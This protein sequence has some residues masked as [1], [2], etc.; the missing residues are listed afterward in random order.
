MKYKSLCKS[1]L[2]V[3]AMCTAFGTI[4][5]F[6]NTYIEAQETDLSTEQKNGTVALTKEENG[7]YTFGNGYLK[8][9]FSIT[10][11]K[12][13][14]EYLTNYRTS[15]ETKMTP[16]SSEEFVI[17]T[18][19]NSQEADGFKAPTQKIEN[20]NWGVTSDSEQVAEEKGN[21]SHM[22]DGN[23]DTY[24]HSKYKDASQE[25][26]QYPHNIYVDL[27]NEN[28][29][30]SVYYKQRVHNGSPTV[31]GH[32]KDFKLYTASSIEELKT[33]KAKLVYEGTFE[34]KEDNYVNLGKEVT[35]QYVRIEF[36]TVHTPKDSKVDKD[37]ACCSEFGFFADEAVFPEKSVSQIKASNLTV[38]GVPEVGEAN[39]YKTFR[40][41]D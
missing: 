9:T 31:S 30:K 16:A 15:G 25:E 24:Y 28:T 14:T 38:D 1:A 3:A 23:V 5:P 11:G 17:E 34:D 40:Y 41:G 4:V 18:M 8:R 2:A 20:N 19:E 13:K 35:A 22:F 29:F 12:L 21:A 26:K 33:D 37:V 32:V 39:G 27:K 7:N 10:D 36:T 6:S